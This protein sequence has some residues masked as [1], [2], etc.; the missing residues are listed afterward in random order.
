[1]S[2]PASI[3]QKVKEK[4]AFVRKTGFDCPPNF[5]QVLSW[6]YAAFILI[7][8]TIT[9]ITLFQRES[10]SRGKDIGIGTLSALFIIFY[11]AMI[12]TTVIITKSDPTDPTIA[13][14]R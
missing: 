3:T 11:S 12:L 9:V 4:G 8:F 13:L 1:M 14:E 7:S 10:K 5:T 2:Q 6:G